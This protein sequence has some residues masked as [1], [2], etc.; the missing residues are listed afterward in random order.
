MIFSNS[1]KKWDIF[2][3]CI[4]G[5]MDGNPFVEQWIS[6]VFWSDNEKKEIEGFQVMDMKESIA[7]LSSYYKERIDEIDLYSL[8]YQ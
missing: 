1:V 2:E 6:G 8:L 7:V 4:D 5:P 3:V